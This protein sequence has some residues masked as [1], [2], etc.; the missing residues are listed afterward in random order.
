MYY[1]SIPVVVKSIGIS[2]CLSMYNFYTKTKDIPIIIV[3]SWD[4][5][6]SKL[7]KYS[8]GNLQEMQ[9]QLYPWLNLLETGMFEK[10]NSL[11]NKL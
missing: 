4:N 9:D 11:C 7:L 1:G 2:K 10:I 8:E 3:D 6:E 5:I